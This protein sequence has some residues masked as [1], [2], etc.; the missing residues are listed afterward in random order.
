[1]IKALI[2]IT[3]LIAGSAKADDGVRAHVA[4]VTSTAVGLSLGAAELN[5]LGIAA[6][7]VKV[8]AYREIEAAPEEEKPLLRNKFK[9]FGVGATANNVCIIAGILTGGASSAVCIPLGLAA[10]YLSYSSGE[11]QA[12]KEAFEA[13]CVTQKQLNPLIRCEYRE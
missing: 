6:I 8:L 10:G 7:G 2:L 13:I 11:K 5:P 9:A 3:L 4:D 1:M 12:Q